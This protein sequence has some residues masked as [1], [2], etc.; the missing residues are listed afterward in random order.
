MI[1]PRRLIIFAAIAIAVSALTVF[2]Y[3]KKIDFFYAIDLKLKDVRFRTRGE[4]KPDSRVVIVAIDEKSVK[5]IGR[6]P[7][8]RKIIARLIENL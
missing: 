4:T 7:W 8:D 2:L 3:S 1:K 6:W 5:E